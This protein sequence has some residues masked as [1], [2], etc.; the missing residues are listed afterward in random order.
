MKNSVEA[1][2]P[3]APQPSA[4]VKILESYDHVKILQTKEDLSLVYEIPLPLLSPEEMNLLKKIKDIAITNIEIDPYSIPD[5]QKRKAV[6]LEKVKEIIEAHAPELLKDRQELIAGIAV[7]DMVG[8]GPLDLLLADDN[9]EDILVI[10]TNKPVY[11]VHRKFGKCK[12]RII[13]N[14]DSEVR[15]IIDR[16]AR[17]IGRTVDPLSPLLDA[18]LPDGSRVNATMPPISLGGPT[19]SIRK[20]REDPL[21]ITDLIRFNT[22]TSEVAALLWVCVEGLKVKPANIICAGGSTCGKTTTV[23]C[24]AAF[25]PEPERIVTIEDTAELKLPLRHWI[26]FETRPPNIEGKGEITMDDLLKNT[27][28]MRPD[29][30]IVGEVRGGEAKTLFVAMNTGHDGCM[31]TIHADSASEVITRLTNPPM[32]VPEIMIPA[33]DLIVMQQKFQY[34]DGST[35]RPITEIAEIAGMEGG[36]TQLNRIYR[37]SPRTNLLQATGVL[38]GFKIE[39]ANFKGWST[40]QVD[41]EIQKR[42]VVLEW[43][44]KKKIRKVTEVGRII[45]AYYQDPSSIYSKASK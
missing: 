8:Y 20:F 30:I 37:W 22:L 42:K 21:T 23:N 43:I 36:L 35:F 12:T 34:S 27:L 9:L 7:R 32:N 5:I 18:R 44:I 15:E 17:S 26:R 45:Q 19:I 31:G 3:P 38:S 28:R 13:F 24:L 25:V 14:S 39:L 11:V 10:G 40:E 29:R 41:E 6:F 1:K 33:L 2:V 4:E 16:I